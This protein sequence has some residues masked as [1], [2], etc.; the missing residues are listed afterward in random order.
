ME[1]KKLSW[2]VRFFSFVFVIS[3]ICFIIKNVGAVSY[4]IE[5]YNLDS[6]WEI[7]LNFYDYDDT[8]KLV[9]EL[10]WDAVLED[11]VKNVVLQVNY[12]NENVMNEY[13]PGEL[14]ITISNNTY[15][16]GEY[17]TL[18]D[19]TT[20]DE[21]TD[22]EWKL[23]SSGK[24]I[25]MTNN[26]TI[27]QYTNLEG[28][29]QIAF[30]PD[31]AM[32]VNGKDY[33]YVASLS[34]GDVVISS[35]SISLKFS[36]K[37]MD[38]TFTSSSSKLNGYD[39]LPDNADDY[40]WV[41][42]QLNF[43]RNDNSGVR[44]IYLGTYRWGYYRDYPTDDTL[45]DSFYF[46]QY[47]PTDAVVLDSNM[48]VLTNDAG[49]V[50]ITSWRSLWARMYTY[51][52]VGYPKDKYENAKITNKAEVYGIYWDET[53][54]E[55][56]GTVTNTINM[57]DFSFEYT[58]IG[59][60]G[61][62]KRSDRSQRVSKLK[63]ENEGSTASY[64]FQLTYNWGGVKEDIEIGDD[65][66]YAL[67]EDND[68]VRLTSDEFRFT[69]VNWYG[70][71]LF[72]ANEG[73]I[74]DYELELWVKY[75]G[76]SKYVKYGSTFVANVNN[77]V[78]FDSSEKVI[79][80][81]WIIKDVEES[82]KADPNSTLSQYYGY[83]IT[84][85]CKVEVKKNDLLVGGYVYNFAYLKFYQNGEWINKA[86][87]TN[88]SEGITRDVIAPM[89][90]SEHGDYLSRVVATEQVLDNSVMMRVYERIDNGGLL[91]NDVAN[92]YYKG[93]FNI[94]TYMDFSYGNTESFDGFVYYSLLPKGMEF[95]SISDF[96]NASNILLNNVTTVSGASLTNEYLKEHFKYEVQANYEGSGRTLITMKWDFSDDPLNMSSDLFDDGDIN[97]LW[98]PK[99]Y[100]N[101]IV[102]YESY[103]EFGDKYTNVI[104]MEP[105]NKD[106]LDFIPL[107]AINDYN[108]YVHTL[109]SDPYNSYSRY[110]TD[111]LN[112]ND[113][114]NDVMYYAENSLDILDLVASYQDVLVLVQT[115]E[116]NYT[117][118]ETKVSVST[119]YSYKLRIRPGSNDITN[120]IVYNNI[121]TA[122]GD[123]EHWSG[124]FN[125]V[126]TSYAEE[127]GF[128]VKV[129]YSE[130][131]DAG[132]L[133]DDDSWNEYIEGKTDKT[134]VKSV[135]FE[136]LN[137]D[138]TY[139]FIP[140]KT[141]TYVEVKMLSLEKDSAYA[142]YN[143]CRTEWNAYDDG[144]LV[145][146]VV[147]IT[148]N[149]VVVNLPGVDIEEMPEENKNNIQ[150]PETDAENIILLV[151]MIGSFVY[152]IINHKKM[153]SISN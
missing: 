98:F 17:I 89:D 111:D 84:M 35:N 141:Y 97:S 15:Y 62:L 76:S 109:S 68:Y 48:N 128:Y 151:M 56:I 29:I 112:D 90:Y 101:I 24:E 107:V 42:Y 95:D 16:N 22:A 73:S 113:K 114:T 105:I 94:S 64:H 3:T 74:K 55:V 147:G 83:D 46:L 57:D 78:S 136:F 7:D 138:G 81:K 2:S 33:D 41:K 32:M 4:S 13:A 11:E 8:L 150:I 80:Y 43:V 82:I 124:N 77:A 144:V 85:D 86:E 152:L 148:S 127:Q 21:S 91:V 117:T 40:V 93:S 49:K 142:T 115:D 153:K 28:S 65:Y 149:I 19:S 61:L 139:A 118:N 108:G 135:A 96:E 10:K 116:S 132:S 26:V 20:G 6:N 71:K 53:E 103:L 14:T 18:I 58:G 50:K 119:D 27:S 79:A 122:Y 45:K 121:E 38:Y 102:P 52:I 30:R 5:T 88:Y 36:S 140:K 100:L 39:G 1:L 123:N 137:E 9:D 87:L 99:F 47:V 70:K 31:P 126:D 25:V 104:Y 63:A 59:D 69:E 130:N 129:W 66:V 145:K 125:G 34:Y 92:G 72:N 120:L 67:N 134:L 110:D 146:N 12:K 106:N 131:S 75:A 133:S 44:E 143:N 60:G 37:R 54:E 51:L 23:L